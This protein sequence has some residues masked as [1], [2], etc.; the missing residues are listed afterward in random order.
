MPDTAIPDDLVNAVRHARSIAVLTGA[1]VSAESGIPTFRDAQTGMWAQYNPVELAT[2]EAFFKDPGRVTRWYDERRAKMAECKPNPGHFAL[3]HLEQWCRHR[4]HDFI[5]ITQNIDRLHQAAGSQCVLEL[6]GTIWEWR[7]TKTGNQKEYRDF[8]FSEYPPKSEAGGM[9]R[10]AVVW[11]GEVPPLDVFGEAEE[12]ARMC[13]VFFTIG[14]SA[15]VHPAAGL[16][17]LARAHGAWVVEVN[18]NPTCASQRVDWN[19]RAPSGEAL[20]ALMARLTEP[21]T[22]V[23]PAT[24]G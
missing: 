13:D 5:L 23:R 15:E 22:E 11:F 7:C 10:P 17:D 4:S 6:H 20:P 18:P 9:L 3:A 12:A 14:T 1:G 8:P 24:N 19:L 2:P 16:I 21:R